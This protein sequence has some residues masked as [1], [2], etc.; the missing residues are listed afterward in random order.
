[1]VFVPF[2]SA[3]SLQGM[4]DAELASLEKRLQ[5]E[6]EHTRLKVQELEDALQKV[7]DAREG[8]IRARKDEEERMRQP[9][10]ICFES[11]ATWSELES[12]VSTKTEQSVTFSSLLLLLNC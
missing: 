5:Y 3:V 2:L 1:M 7:R 8:V 9:C 6:L 10:A 4:D 11:L 12:V